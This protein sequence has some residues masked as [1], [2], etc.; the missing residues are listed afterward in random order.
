M[1]QELAN[2]QHKDKT[3]YFV[4]VLKTMEVNDVR[5]VNAGRKV[6]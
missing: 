5:S 3:L 4:L 6:D 1:T 2:A